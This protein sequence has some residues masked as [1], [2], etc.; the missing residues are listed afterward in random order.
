MAKMLIENF[1]LEDDEFNTEIKKKKI[2]KSFK[3]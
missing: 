2:F 1:D 3:N